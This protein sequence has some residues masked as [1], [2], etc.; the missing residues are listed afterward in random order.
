MNW[1]IYFVNLLYIT[2]LPTLAILIQGGLDH[3]FFPDVFP[4]WLQ[5]ASQFF[6]FLYVIVMIMMLSFML[7]INHNKKISLSILLGGPA[8]GLL[9]AWITGSQLTYGIY[10]FYLI[11]G[12]GFIFVLTYQVLRHTKRIKVESG[13]YALVILIIFIFGFLLGFIRSI[14]MDFFLQM[15]NQWYE[16]LALFV[17][18]L[19][20]FSL[21]FNILDSEDKAHLNVKTAKFDPLKHDSK[22]EKSGMPFVLLATVLGF[23][24]FGFHEYLLEIPWLVDFLQ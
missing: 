3:E 4:E 17:F 13:P 14:N 10:N 16:F 21:F 11:E 18:I 1:L 24:A 22:I 15:Y 7:K 23:I 20:S 19:L 6:F 5:K 8:I 12:A 9:L 2:L